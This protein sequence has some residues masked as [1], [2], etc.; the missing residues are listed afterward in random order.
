MTELLKTLFLTTPGT[1]LH[2][3]GDTVRIHHPERPGRHV[4]PL[5]RIEQ[6][7]VWR[8][9]EVSN[10]L[11]HRCAEDSRGITWL[12]RNGRFLNRTA[13]AQTGNP[14]LRLEQV[15]AY[16]DQSRRLNL[17]KTI[18]A[19]KIHNYRQLL[20]RTA[21]DVSGTR[22]ENLRVLAQQHADAL[23]PLAGSSSLSEVLGIEGQVARSY[24][25]AMHLLAPGARPGRTRRPPMDAF[26]CLLSFG[27]GM[28][29]V[30]VV[31]AL[32]HVGLDPY[33]GYL[34][35]VRSGKPSLALDL[36][37]EFRPLLVDRL[38]ATLF[39]RN[40]ITAAHTETLPGGAV[41]LTEEGRA[42]FLGQWS[43]A[44]ERLWKHNQLQREVPAALLPVVQA[45][46]LARYLRGDQTAYTPWA[47]T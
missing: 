35:G 15:R 4:L 42:L 38:V 46:L 23:H 34:H 17:A 40:Q 44:R 24:F 29:R 5:V 25:Q 10:E 7:V 28:L 9:V 8:G 47:A 31:G 11:M 20:L 43:K 21:R 14:L 26:N 36:M 13:G 27:Y 32:E 16:D 30:A 45:R 6:L 12:S 18:V 19:G 22:K 41:Q 2:L 1:S 39:N 3:E 37:E 33:I